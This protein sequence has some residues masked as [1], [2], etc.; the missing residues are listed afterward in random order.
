MKLITHAAQLAVMR[1]E[2]IFNLKL[3]I[4]AYIIAL[5]VSILYLAIKLIGLLVKVLKGE[6]IEWRTTYS[7]GSVLKFSLIGAIVLSAIS[8]YIYHVTDS[9][10]VAITLFVFFMALNIA[11][12]IRTLLTED[13][14]RSRGGTKAD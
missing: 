12:T 3:L 9:F 7:F 4:I 1:P 13:H 14:I 2:D 10:E 5:S 8:F 6:R 11:A